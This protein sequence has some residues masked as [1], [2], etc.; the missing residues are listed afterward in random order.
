[1][2][3]TKEKMTRMLGALLVLAFMAFACGTEDIIPV[4]TEVEQT[5]GKVNRNLRTSTGG[6]TPPNY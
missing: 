5:T 2:K 6:V 4:S 1:M 3:K